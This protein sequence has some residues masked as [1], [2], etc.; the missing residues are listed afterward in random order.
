MQKSEKPDRTPELKLNGS[1]ADGF[2][3]AANLMKYDLVASGRWYKPT[4]MMPPEF[5]GR[6][7]C[8]VCE[9]FAMHDWKHHKEQLTP[10]CPHCGAKMTNGSDDS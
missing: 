5:T 3:A 9:G 1:D 4:G 2:L 8:S 6:H 10:F 7:R